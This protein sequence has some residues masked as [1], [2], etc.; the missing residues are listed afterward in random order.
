MDRTATREDVLA[1]ELRE[2]CSLIEFLHGCL[3]EPHVE[4]K[5]GGYSYDYPEQTLARL[6]GWRMMTKD[7]PKCSAKMFSSMHTF[8]CPIHNSAFQ[9]L[10]SRMEHGY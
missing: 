8:D 5:P 3:T 1:Y 6:T 7:A 4:G 9:N 10:R 2:A